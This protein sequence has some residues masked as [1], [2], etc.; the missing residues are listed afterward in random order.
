M[1]KFHEIGNYKTAKNV[2]YCVTEVPLKN[3]MGVIVDE[4]AR[5]VSLP[6]TGAS[7]ISVVMSIIDKPEIHSPNEYV[8]EAGEYPR[9]FQLSSITGK[10]VD[11]DT[12]VI[13]TDYSSVEA[14]DILVYD[15]DGKL[16]KGA[17]SET[18]GYKVIEKTTFGGEGILAKVLA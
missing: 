5:K 10:L 18:I 12:D 14:G 2:G 9:T 11:M 17:G 8:I 16:K 1:F 3:G 6:T 4:A 13:T 15:T 7:D